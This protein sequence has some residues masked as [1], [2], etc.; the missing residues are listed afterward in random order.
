MTG[1]RKC[2]L[3]SG[4]LLIIVLSAASCLLSQSTDTDRDDL[5]IALRTQGITDR[6]VLAAMKKVPREVF[7]DKVFHSAAYRNTALPI[8]EGQTIS[9]PL[10]VALMTQALALKGNERVLEVGTGSGYQAAILGEI[11]QKVYTIEIKPGLAESARQRLKELGYRNIE[12]RVG[13]GYKGWPEAAPFDAVMVTASAGKIPPPLLE[14]L[15]E[16]GRLIMPVGQSG[17]KQELTLVTKKNGKIH[18]SVLADVAFV[19]MTGEAE[20][21]EAGRR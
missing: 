6:R 20:K 19:R 12:V 3:A 2:L 11:V 21:G 7:V 15:A 17:Y 18:A 10:V 9:Q 1:M 5:L 14:Q 4:F 8:A 16:N 13:D